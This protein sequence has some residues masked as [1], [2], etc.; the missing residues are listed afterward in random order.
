MS[1]QHLTRA[2]M[3]AWVCSADRVQLSCLTLLFGLWVDTRGKPCAWRCPHPECYSHSRTFQPETNRTSTGEHTPS[4][5]PRSDETR[6]SRVL[7]L[8]WSILSTSEC[9]RCLW[10]SLQVQMSAQKVDTAFTASG[11]GARQA[12]GDSHEVL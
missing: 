8:V 2:K 5:G 6:T 11:S 1:Q 7:A 4:S 12:H 9:N 10:Y 3:C